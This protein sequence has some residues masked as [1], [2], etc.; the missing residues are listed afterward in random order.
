VILA[1]LFGL[2]T[3]LSMSL[4][5]EKFNEESRRRTQSSLEYLHDE[6]E[7]QRVEAAEGVAEVARDAALLAA[8]DA[9]AAGALASESS[10]MT[11]LAA[12]LLAK[13][14]LD[15]L[16]ILDESGRILSI[17]QWPVYAGHADSSALPL[18]GIE[19][20]MPRVATIR[21]ERHLSV[22]AAR[23]L[24]ARGR[25]FIVAG[26]KL[27]DERFVRRIEKA[28]GDE[29]LLY[30][31]QG[32]EIIV[33]GRHPERKS[34]LPQDVIRYG[35]RWR[36]GA[37]SKDLFVTEVKS[38]GMHYSL[39]TAPLH[40][41]M[42]RIIG[43]IMVRRSEEKLLELLRNLR[44]LFLALA[45]AGMIVAWAAAYLAARSITRPVAELARA[46]SR[47]AAGELS[48]P[49][50]HE[51]GEMEVAQ[52]A[53]AWNA[54]WREIESGRA[55]LARAERLAAW[56]EAA[57]RI[58]H[59]IRNT[60]Y[61]IRLSVDTIERAR[62][63]RSPNFEEVLSEGAE[64]VRS[65]VADLQR[66][67]EEFSAFA[68]WP[69]PRRERCDA[70]ALLRRA[71]E[72]L[73]ADPAVAPD[74]PVRLDVRPG[75]GLPDLD[76]DPV[77]VGQLLTNLLRNA[78][79]AVG[80]SGVIRLRA[81]RVPEGVAFEVRDDGPGMPPDVLARAREPYFTGKPRG[82]GLGLAIVQQ[83]VDA[84][85][86]AFELSSEPGAGTIATVTLPAAS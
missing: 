42:G 33:S 16:E 56:R 52:L 40:D 45:G 46:A 39:G 38:G 49:P 6:Y 65:A 55:R 81:F 70:N 44:V 21:G 54:M 67:V 12:N 3:L 48:P 1:V 37:D 19:E 71:A 7:R 29:V 77:Q 82:S 83:I 10:E 68:R 66:I 74:G 20:A 28:A 59:E 35:W 76:A 17:G 30:F 60:L 14:R 18:A 73:A 64:N 51:P 8:I 61:P 47:V 43:E 75:D 72:A 34:L 84:H 58:A 25:T 9:V 86:G 36:A 5:T 50:V 69:E 2:V 23:T 26:G 31:V 27:L 32:S 79:E 24:A 15:L 62:A 22:Q 41:E 78:R 13:S 11:Y 57:R 85:G 4:V 63:Q 53:R 80:D